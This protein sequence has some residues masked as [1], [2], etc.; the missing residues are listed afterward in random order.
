MAKAEAE[1]KFPSDH[2]TLTTF[3]KEMIFI[4][5]KIFNNWN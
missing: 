2:S 3:S 4:I 5:F 1:P